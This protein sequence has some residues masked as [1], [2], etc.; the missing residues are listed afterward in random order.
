ME[1]CTEKLIEMSKATSSGLVYATR[2]NGRWDY[3]DQSEVSTLRACGEDP[4][5][6]Y[7]E[8]GGDV[9]EFVCVD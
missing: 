9:P 7:V 5:K 2:R 3:V 6:G 8:F 1:L 4:A